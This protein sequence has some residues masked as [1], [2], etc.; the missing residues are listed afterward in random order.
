MSKEEIR[1]RLIIDEIM[2]QKTAGNAD[3]DRN[4][5]FFN[6]HYQSLFRARLTEKHN[7]I[8]HMYQ[9]KHVLDCRAVLNEL[10]KELSNHNKTGAIH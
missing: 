9:T 7:N 3:A 1:E 10:F 2:H 4:N 6:E 8:R 5:I